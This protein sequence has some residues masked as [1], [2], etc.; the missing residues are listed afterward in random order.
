[1][2]WVGFPCRGSGPFHS[3]ILEFTPISFSYTVCSGIP[4]RFFIS[5]SSCKV[6]VP[7]TGPRSLLPLARPR[8]EPQLRT[9]TWL[10]SLALPL[11]TVAPIS[12]QALLSPGS[13]LGCFPV[14]WTLPLRWQLYPGDLP[15]GGSFSGHASV[16]QWQLWVRAGVGEPISMDAN[17]GTVSSKT[18]F[19]GK[20]KSNSNV[21]FFN[22]SL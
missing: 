4:F 11:L 12:L 14:L 6:G 21:V 13:S 2:G 22:C 20:K 3:F 8:S 15:G 1:M 10:T 5:F 9:M 7:V 16:Y 19:S 17:S 18:V